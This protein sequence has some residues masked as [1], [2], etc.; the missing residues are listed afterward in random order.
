MRMADAALKAR[1]TRYLTA[2]ASGT[3]ADVLALVDAA[4]FIHHEPRAANG[5]EGFISWFKATV[6]AVRPVRVFRDTDVVVI[7]SECTSRSDGTILVRFDVVRFSDDTA[8]VVEH[9]CAAQKLEGPS[10]SG[11]TMLDGPTDVVDLDKTDTNKA[12][13]H[14]YVAD[15]PLGGNP[16]AVRSYFDG[17]AYIQHNAWVGDTLPGLLAGLQT[18]AKAGKTVKYHHEHAL[19]GEG[20][21]VLVVAAGNFGEQ[22][23]AYYDMFRLHDG[24]IAEHWDVLEAVPPVSEWKGSH[25][26]F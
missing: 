2:L 8:R 4:K 24:K 19:Y 6:A 15:V 16:A 9:W 22:P 23:T 1:A 10:P 12:V 5:T 18:L 21:F 20:N 13:M 11:H 26:K 25:G 17:V 7:H 14:A 3:D